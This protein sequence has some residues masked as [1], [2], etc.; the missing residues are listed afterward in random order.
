MLVSSIAR[1]TALNNMNNAAFNTMQ[2]SNHMMGAFN[3]A[4]AFGG[5]HDLSMLNKL[6]NKISMDLASNKLLYKVSYLQEKMAAKH[7]DLEYNKKSLNLL[8]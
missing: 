6:D 1:F 8:A 3:N 7:Q 5:E 4:S 2:A